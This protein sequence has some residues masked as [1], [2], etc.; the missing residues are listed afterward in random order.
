MNI[1][2]KNGFPRIEFLKFQIAIDKVIVRIGVKL[3]AKLEKTS[4]KL[5]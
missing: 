2:D 1:S 5:I 4:L 3:S